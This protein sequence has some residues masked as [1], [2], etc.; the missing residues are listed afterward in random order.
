[1]IVGR[2]IMVEFLKM[3]AVLERL[4][5]SE[6]SFRYLQEVPVNLYVTC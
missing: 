1:M 4:L 6:I 5:R 3:S 2:S